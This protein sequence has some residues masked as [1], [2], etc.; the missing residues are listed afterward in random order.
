VAAVL[1]L[2]SGCLFVFPQALVNLDLGSTP[3][4]KLTAAARLQ[5][6]NDVRT[7]LLQGLAGSFFL[8]TAYF[9]WRQIRISQQQLALS[10][11]QQTSE[12]FARAIE[13]VEKP[14]INA[15]LGGIYTLEEIARTSRGYTETVG[16]VLCAYVRQQA[17]WPR[18]HARLQEG[19]DPDIQ[20]ILTVLGR[21][22]GPLSVG[23]R[24]MNLCDTDLGGADLRG[25]TLPCVRLMRSN[26]TRARLDDARLDDAYLINADLR[27]AK[28]E[29]VRLR[30]VRLIGASLE[31]AR[32]IRVD[33][34]GA[35]LTSARVDHKTR[36]IAAQL[37]G[38]TLRKVDLEAT[39]YGQLS[40]DAGT[41]WPDGFVLREDGGTTGVKTGTQPRG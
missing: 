25:L 35:D 17:P 40:F 1:V 23:A 9:T 26:L 37:E 41:K 21:T 6:I 30:G 31:G 29:R 27:G 5:A 15:K 24:P 36:I 28:L 13:Q 3:S 38:A 19:V 14:G 20:A 34:R 16:E 4:S 10:D 18:Q 7:T 32:L 2:L 33:L 12:R 11:E 39:R 8:A 22:L